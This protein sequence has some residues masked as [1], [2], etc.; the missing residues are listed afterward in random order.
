MNWKIAMG[1]LGVVVCV[2]AGC[3]APQTNTRTERTYDDQY[4]RIGHMSG[5]VDESGLHFRIDPTQAFADLA[6]DQGVSTEELTQ[7]TFG[8]GGGRGVNPGGT[9]ELVT[10]R[11]A[12]SPACSVQY[13]PTLEPTTYPTTDPKYVTA[14]GTIPGTSSTTCYAADV[15]LREH[16]GVELSNVYI[17]FTGTTSAAGP[18]VVIPYGGAVGAMG[19]SGSLNNNTYRYGSLEPAP[20]LGEG[21]NFNA[22]FHQASLRRWRFAYPAGTTDFSFSFQ[23]NVFATIATSR[24]PYQASVSAGGDATAS[25]FRAGC[26]SDNG[27]VHVGVAIEPTTSTPQIYWHRRRTGELRWVS[28]NATGE[29]GSGSTA[30]DAVGNACV[31]ADGSLVVFDS[32]YPLTVTDTSTSTLDVY[33]VTVANGDVEHISHVGAGSATAC[34]GAAVVG[35]LRPAVSADGAFIAFE[36][37]CSEFCGAE[38]GCSAGR[39]QIYRYERGTSSLIGISQTNA[40]SFNFGTA[41]STFAS[42]SSDGT[43]ISFQSQSTNLI[44]PAETGSTIDVYVRDVSTTSTTRITDNVGNGYFA[45]QLSR[46]G[47][48]VL[49]VSKSS[50]FVAGV[51]DGNDLDVFRCASTGTGCAYVSLANGSTAVSADGD[52]GSTTLVGASISADGNIIAFESLSDA[53]V[54]GD[55]N[56]VRDVFVRNMTTNQT[57]RIS[58]DGFGSECDGESRSPRVS[59]NSTGSVYV[60]F[61]SEATNIMFDGSGTGAFDGSDGTASDVFSVRL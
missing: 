3:V 31:S 57:L 4:V 10:C 12:T 29:L 39:S 5:Y 58:T 28:R 54:S 53:L 55:T 2:G 44:T 23:G 21:A 61:E 38:V 52:S 35:S 46:D 1:P 27:D 24:A 22:P 40:S 26:V 18:N 36:S 49:F 32:R 60:G 11:S 37:T 42:I 8:T 6:E 19:L 33:A 16:L 14:C 59:A 30:P 34:G 25:A 41:H 7:L 9:Y 50:A 17:A 20:L 51:S 56:L 48:F 13:G 15:E 45:S 43:R 47:A